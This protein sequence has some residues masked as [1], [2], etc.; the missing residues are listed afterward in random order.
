MVAIH[1]TATDLYKVGGMDRKAMRK[2]DALPHSDA[3][4]DAE[5]DSRPADTRESESNGLCGLPE[6]D[7]ELSRQM[8]T[9]RKA[10]AGNFPY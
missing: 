9:R 8:G 10:P 3:G 5:E 6:C 7:A 4:D 2:F 1:E